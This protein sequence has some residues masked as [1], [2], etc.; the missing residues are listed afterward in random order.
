M[1]RFHFFR[2]F[3]SHTVHR[4][5]DPGCLQQHSGLPSSGLSIRGLST[6]RIRNELILMLLFKSVAEP[7][8]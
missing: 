2:E 5:R 6:A 1:A 8:F 3:F 7:D 4:V